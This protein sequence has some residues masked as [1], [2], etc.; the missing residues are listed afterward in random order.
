[1]GGHNKRNPLQSISIFASFPRHNRNPFSTRPPS[2]SNTGENPSLRTS[3]TTST[4]THL[5]KTPPHGSKSRDCKELLHVAVSYFGT[6]LSFPALWSLR[7]SLMRQ[8][9]PS[10]PQVWQITLP[11][12]S[13][14][15]FWTERAN[16]FPR[17]IKVVGILRYGFLLFL[18]ICGIG[19]VW[20]GGGG[21]ESW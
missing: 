9:A 19:M 7:C 21:L 1:M 18:C 6:L 4:S 5:L 10:W 16:D 8:R 14:L 15:G 20:E 13:D 11:N 2:I 12:A 3:T 17:R